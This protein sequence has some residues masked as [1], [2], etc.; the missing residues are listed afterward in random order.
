M[1]DAF[2]AR[3]YATIRTVLD[4]LEWDR[5][6]RGSST[7]EQK[8]PELTSLLERIEDACDD[9][10]DYELTRLAL[11]YWIDETMA[12]ATE[13]QS[14]ASPVRQAF[15]A[16]GGDWEYFIKSYQAYDRGQTDALETF[17][18]CAALG[19]GGAYRT[20]SARTGASAKMP[21]TLADWANQ[22]L[23]KI[24]AEPPSRFDPLAP[25]VAYD[26]ETDALPLTGRQFLKRS[27]TAL[28]V[29]GSLA[30]VLGGIWVCLWLANP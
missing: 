9:G 16:A 1:N 28:A 12:K 21:P 15:R 8:I 14:H 20:G 27:L 30:A 18:L 25:L 3:V 22:I 17:Y 13:G 23:R 5:A 2:A 29:T 10:L 24:N 11:E 6:R 26:P 4:A 19:F 7:I